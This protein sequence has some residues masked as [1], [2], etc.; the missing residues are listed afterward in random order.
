MAKRGCARRGRFAG[1]ARSSVGRDSRSSPSE[2]RDQPT[3]LL[4]ESGCGLAHRL[5]IQGVEEA[6]EIVAVADRKRP[7]AA[8][9]GRIS[10]SYVR[11]KGRT[12]QNQTFPQPVKPRGTPDLGFTQRMPDPSQMQCGAGLF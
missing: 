2:S 9:A 10:I 12:L 8:N 1:G 4:G 3:F 6:A 5:S 11:P 7:S